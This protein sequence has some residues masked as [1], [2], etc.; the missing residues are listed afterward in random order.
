MIAD[1]KGMPK[2]CWCSTGW[3]MDYLATT[4]ENIAKNYDILKPWAYGLKMTV[5]TKTVTLEDDGVIAQVC[6]FIKFD[7]KK[8]S[9]ASIDMLGLQMGK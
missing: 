4:P 8:Q 7:A 3:F 2:H 1:T 6:D 9:S 5:R